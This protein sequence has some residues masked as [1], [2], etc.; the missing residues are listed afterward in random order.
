M[1]TGQLFSASGATIDGASDITFSGR[2]KF[3]RKSRNH[4]IE[5]EPPASTI[6][7]FSNLIKPSE[8][9]LFPLASTIT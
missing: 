9:L 3:N 7:N 6:I 2:I 4:Y 1:E 8:R 5:Y